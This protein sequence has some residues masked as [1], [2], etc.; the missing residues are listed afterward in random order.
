MHKKRR[1][2][3]ENLALPKL[4]RALEELERLP[5]SEAETTTA[6]HPLIR[7]MFDPRTGVALTF[8]VM[9]R[10]SVL[11]VV[12]H[13]EFTEAVMSAGPAPLL[14]QLPPLPYP[15]VAVECA[16]NVVWEM[17]DPDGNY[18]WDLEILLINEEG[19]GGPW[20]IFELVRMA[21]STPEE[22]DSRI[23]IFRIE[24]DG[25]ITEYD[26]TGLDELGK[27]PPM[28]NE[29]DLQEWAERLRK[30]HSNW[31]PFPHTRDDPHSI[32]LRTLP[33]EFAHLINARGV[34]LE[35]VEPPRGERRQLA[36]KK[37]VHPQV[38]FVDVGATDEEQER[39]GHGEREY[40]CRWMVRGHWRRY[41]N[42]ETTWIRPY[43]KGPPGAPW[44]GRP[45]YVLS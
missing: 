5:V 38:Y 39:G 19:Q 25:G 40:H 3:L 42:G 22:P 24:R 18:L 15:R 13:I 32:A 36:R 14:P 34:R 4:L 8:A 30:A 35:P 16:E 17:D 12:D 1:V 44:K 26:V 28:R 41:R 21:G 33:I 37:F 45:I 11:F 29:S 10:T 2:R 31:Q 23:R 7:A 43:I 27:P 6:L 9:A 20:D